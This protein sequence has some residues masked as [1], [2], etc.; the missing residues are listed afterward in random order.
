MVN[1]ASYV[2]DRRDL[3]WLTFDPQA[4]HEQMGRRPALVISPKTYNDKVGL[5]LF[6]PTTRQEKGYPFEVRIPPGIS[7]TGVILSDQVKNLDWKSRRATFIGRL[8]EVEFNAVVQNI[9]ALIA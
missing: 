2:P 9:R 5:A 3:V 1:G 7:C 8:P 4:G 6:C